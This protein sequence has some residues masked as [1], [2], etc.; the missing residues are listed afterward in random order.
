MP[1]PSPSHCPR[2]GLPADSPTSPAWMQPQKLEVAGDRHKPGD[3]NKSP[4]QMSQ[5]SRGQVP[6]VFRTWWE[7]RRRLGCIKSCGAN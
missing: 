5:T 7:V 3:F 6:L 2:P 1:S 4:R